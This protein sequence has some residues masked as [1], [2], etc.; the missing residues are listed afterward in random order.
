M[1]WVIKELNKLITHL[2][3]QTHLWPLI[4]KLKNKNMLTP[5]VQ[6]HASSSLLK[7]KFIVQMLEI[8]ELF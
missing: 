6:P 8:V 5:K 3:S 7:P 2:P 4:N 1:N